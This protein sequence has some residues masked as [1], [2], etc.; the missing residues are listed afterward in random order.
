MKMHVIAT[1][2][3]TKDKKNVKSFPLCLC[4]GACAER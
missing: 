1:D 4:A 2:A 3:P